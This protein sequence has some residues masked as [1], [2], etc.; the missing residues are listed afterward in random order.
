M[1]NIE[2]Y[3]KGSIGKKFTEWL[4][5]WQS[6]RIRYMPPQIETTA[7]ILGRLNSDSSNPDCNGWV[8]LTELYALTTVTFNGTQLNFN[9][10]NGIILKAFVNTNTAEIKT[11]AAK[12]LDVEGRE[13]L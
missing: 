6:A 9:P 11:Y 4:L 7:G 13:N 2:L 5:R 8:E 10:A 12:Y 1:K 3:K